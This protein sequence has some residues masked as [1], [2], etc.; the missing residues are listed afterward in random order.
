MTQAR[1]INIRDPPSPDYALGVRDWFASGIRAAIPDPQAALGAGYLVGQRSTL[2]AELDEQLKA[3]G[4]THAVVA[5][6]YNLTILVGFARSSLLRYSK[7]LATLASIAMIVSF[8]L[9][10]GLSPSMTRAGL[11]TG[12]SL[13]AWYFG[14]TIH[15]FVLLPFAAAIT[16]LVDPTY[17]WGDLGWYLSFGSFVGLVVVAPLLK[18]YFWPEEAADN[19]IRGIFL[20]TTSAQLATLPIILY[21]FGQ[22]SAYSLVANM[23]V[24]PFVPLTMLLTFGA[25]IAGLAAP[26]L[27]TWFGLP[28]SAVLN[29]MIT[30]IGWVAGWPGALHEFSFGVPALIAGYGL[31]ALAL[32]TLWR[33]TGYSFKSSNVTLIGDRL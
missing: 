20:E 19:T 16:L 29:Y 26:A 11:V 8:M 4:L 3:V 13:G 32:V 9:I 30:V 25:G 1:L 6:G 33:R 5:S 24:L 21:S 17:I 2:P 7:Y 12:L 14:R 31:L 18:R 27:A 23:L 28:A 22:F 15:P 10:T